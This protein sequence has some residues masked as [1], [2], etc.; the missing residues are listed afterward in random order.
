MLDQLRSAYVAAPPALRRRLAPLVACV[1]VQ[2]RYGAS[3]WQ[4]RSEILQAQHDASWLEQQRLKRLRQTVAAAARA[5]YYQSQFH[6][7]FG[8]M[9]DIDHFTFDD[10]QRLPIVT[11]AVLRADPEALLAVAKD[12]ADV[13]STSGSGGRPVTFWLDKNRGAKEFAYLTHFWSRIG[14]TAGKSRRAVLRG[15]AINGQG[16]KSWQWDAALQELHLSPF[17]FTPQNMQLYCELIEEYQIDFIHGYPSAISVLA[18]YMVHSGWQAP[19]CLKGLLPASE[20]IYPQ[21]EALFDKAFGGLPIARYYGMSEKVLIAGQVGASPGDYAFEPLYGFAELVTEE[22]ALCAVGEKGRIIGT[23]FVSRAMPLLR[24]DTEDMATLRERASRDN[25]WR[26][27]V[28]DIAGRW[29]AEYL[30]GS[31]GQLVPMSAVNAH[32]EAYGKLHCFQLYQD[33]IG[34][35]QL[36]V[37]PQHGVQ[38]SELQPFIDELHAR[39]GPALHFTLQQVE[40]IAFK[41]DN[42]KRPFIDQ[43]LD[44]CTYFAKVARS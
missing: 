17:D 31:G 16:G 9:P 14:F 33:T 11:K 29:N 13:A 26:L 15:V 18:Q 4:T 32:S 2:W 38:L 23:G 7:T 30:V 37:V 24:Y 44:L 25:R 34:H 5:P 12:T 41:T 1:P 40:S 19:T 20:A 3:F 35:V 43:R 27:G 10:L 21:Q 42:G 22:G 39:I 8:G 6:H 36:R 28:S